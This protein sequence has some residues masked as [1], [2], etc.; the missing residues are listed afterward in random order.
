MPARRTDKAGGGALTMSSV[1]KY[2]KIWQ[3]SF[4]DHIIKNERDLHTHL[5]Y[6][7]Y[8]PVKH[9]IVDKPELWKWSSY[10]AFL[11]RGYYEIGWGHSEPKAVKNINYEIKDI[12]G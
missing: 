5:D 6:I 2:F 4:Y 9:K 10:K 7:H 1:K 3:T 11:K 8:N 12:L